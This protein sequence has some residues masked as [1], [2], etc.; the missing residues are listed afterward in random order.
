MIDGSLY[1]DAETELDLSRYPKL[2]TLTIDSLSYENVNVTKF[3]G[4]NE[5][6][7]VEIGSSC[8]TEPETGQFYVKNCPKL[9]SL[10]IGHVSFF[11]YN[12]FEIENVDALEEIEIGS[13]CFTET[14]TGQFYVKNCPKLKSLKIGHVSF[15]KYNVFEIENVDALE[16]IEIGELNKGSN[17]YFASLKLKSV[18]VERK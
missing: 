8:F 12:V 15:L 4:M 7:S 17:F 16:E 9:K 13:S 11:K 6:E 18:T 14:E 10:K 5:L 3:I 1:C 2:K